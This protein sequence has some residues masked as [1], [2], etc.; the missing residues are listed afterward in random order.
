MKKKWRINKPHLPDQPG[1]VLKDRLLE[2]ESVTTRHGQRYILRRWSNF[3]EV[4]KHAITWLAIVLLLIL[5]VGFQENALNSF[6][7]VAV[8]AAG[9]IYSEGVVGSAADFN[10]IFATTQPEQTVTRLVFSSLLE[11]GPDNNLVGDLAD[12]WT[13]DNTGQ[14]YTVHLNP[15]AQWQDGVPV[16][17]ADVVYTIGAIQDPATGSPLASNWAHVEVKALNPQTVQFTL[18]APFPPFINSLT[19]GIIPQHILSRVPDYQLRS[20]SFDTDPTVGSGP[21]KFINSQTFTNQTDIRLTRNS[22][23]YGGHVLPSGFNV[24]AFN[25]YNGLLEAFRVGEISAASDVQP[26]DVH[27]LR[28]LRNVQVQEAPLMNE[29]LAFFNM[30]STVMQDAKVRAALNIAVNK[31]AI[32]DALDDE[33]R[34]ASIPL[35]PGQLGYDATQDVG[36][37]SQTAATTLL[38]SDGYV[39]SKDGLLE[40]NG[41]PLTVNLAASTDDVY[42]KVADLLAKQWQSIGITVQVNLVDDQNIQQN[43]LVPR[44]YDVLVYQLAIGADSDVYAYWDSAEIGE[45]GLNLSNYSNQYVDELLQSAR[46]STDPSLRAVKYHDFVTQWVSDQPAVVLYQPTYNY[47]MRDNVAGF[48]PHPLVQPTDRFYNIADWSAATKQAVE[49]H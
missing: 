32:I 34:A 24:D 6:Y 4:G 18:P 21:Y 19:S 31:E 26:G 38:A 35:L 1:Q 8:P 20:A 14:I 16:T 41:V 17:S 22:N 30:N 2:F 45:Q 29:T 25:D 42:P 11:Y 27:S 10:P 46:T 5:G 49:N 23:Y 28:A 33:Y 13:V 44:N 40:K 43:V 3:T 9:G 12:S 37:F 47:A 15:D 48:I 36:G 7:K 39:K